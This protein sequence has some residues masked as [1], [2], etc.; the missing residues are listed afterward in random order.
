MHTAHILG[1]DAN[2]AQGQGL[3]T[4]LEGGESSACFVLKERR[5]LQGGLVAERKERERL[6]TEENEKMQESI[7]LS[8]VY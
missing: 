2:T 3:H 6:T 8:I 5:L 4:G 7:M 1:W